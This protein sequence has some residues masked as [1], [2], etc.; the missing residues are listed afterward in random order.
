MSAITHLY[1]GVPVSDLDASIDWYARFFGKPPDFRAGDEVL[2]ETD[3]HA[4]LFIEPDAAQAGT[5]RITL[6]VAGLD[7]F[8]E[9]LA[10]QRIEHERP[11]AEGR[12]IRMS[13][14]ARGS[15]RPARC[16]KHAKGG[17][18]GSTIPFSTNR[19]HQTE[20]DG[21]AS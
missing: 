10:A 17:A 5:G 11:A 14:G 8:L 12:S 7:A 21:S 20:I 13:V 19:L 9:R 6:S 18:A 3:E 15:Q 4:T 2:W 1:A 16:R